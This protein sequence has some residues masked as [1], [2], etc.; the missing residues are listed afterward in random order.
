[1]L[2]FRKGKNALLKKK[3]QGIP[4]TNMLESMVIQNSFLSDVYRYDIVDIEFHLH[5]LHLVQYFIEQKCGKNCRHL[6]QYYC[7]STSVDIY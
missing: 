1:M 5:H 2:S 7:V 4:H 6:C 3:R